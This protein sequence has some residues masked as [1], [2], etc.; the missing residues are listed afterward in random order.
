MGQQI[1]RLVQKLQEKG[2]ITLSGS[3]DAFNALVK[4]VKSTVASH[5]KEVS[6]M[7]AEVQQRAQAAAE[8]TSSP[9]SSTKKKSKKSTSKNSKKKIH[10]KAKN[11]TKIRKTKG[12]RVN[13]NNIE[14]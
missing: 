5:Q 14:K 11:P 12:E 3:S 6:A 8:T 7:K 2:I 4:N 9:N 1:R 10:C 13:K